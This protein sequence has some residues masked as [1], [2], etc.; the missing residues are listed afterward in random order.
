MNWAKNNTTL[1][2][3]PDEPPEDSGVKI[4]DLLDDANLYEWG[5]VSMGRADTYRLYLSIKKFAESLPGEVDRLRFFGRVNTRSNPYYIIEGLSAEDEEGIDEE[6]QEGRA[7]V[8]K[9]VY[10]AIQDVESTVWTKLPNVSTEHIV[11]TRQFKRILT[12]DLE[13][14]VPSYPPFP[15]KEKHLLR[16]IIALIVGE[17]SISPDGFFTLDDSEDPP[18]VKP[19]EAED[20]NNNFPKTASDL[21][22]PDAWKHHEIELNKL[23]RIT[24]LPEKLDDNGDP[25]VPDE[26]VEVNP[27]LDALKPE[28][29][30]IRACP[31]GAG[32]SSTSVVVLRSLR[33]PGAVAVASGRRYVNVYVGDGLPYSA[34][35]YS[36]PLPAPIQPE[37]S[38]VNAEGA[39]VSIMTEQVDVRADP[40]PPVPEGEATDE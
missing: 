16:A 27:P 8:N 28:N 22:E 6:K 24:N 3:V 29:W 5:G 15:G 36:P 34:V 9:Y 37:W 39:P 10:W 2:K 12:G 1:L 17:T 18:T 13:S 30:S 4:P 31:G 33:W 7:G 38:T 25:I 21:R 23:G 40:T 32:F 26:P 11:K 19:A 14:A 35:S 20:F